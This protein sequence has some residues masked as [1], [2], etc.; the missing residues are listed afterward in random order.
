MSICVLHQIRILI[1]LPLRLQIEK[2]HFH[3]K[4]QG[5]FDGTNY[6]YGR[7]FAP[8]VTRFETILSSLLH[9][10]VVSYSSGLSALHAALILLNARH[11]SVG[12]GYHG[13]HE[14]IDVVSQLSGLQ[15]LNLDCPAE[16]LRKGD[17]I[18]L[19]TP[20]NPL[21]TA[22]SID[23]YAQKVHS[24][25]AYLIVGSTFGPPGLQDPFQWGADII[26]H[27]GSKYLGGHCA[28]S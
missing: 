25:G 4:Y 26:L 16:D 24:Q 7:E 14:V 8:N 6:V 9:G 21:G 13:S 3:R 1:P 2:T 15:K 23:A 28:V 10:D 12:E 11:I 22:F 20:V 19:E 5:E 27:S 18:L 17:V